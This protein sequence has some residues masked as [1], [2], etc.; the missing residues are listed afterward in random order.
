MQRAH[1]ACRALAAGAVL[2]TAAALLPACDDDPPPAPKPRI[3]AIP[4]RSGSATSRPATTRSTTSAKPLAASSAGATASASSSA[5]PALELRP[6]RKLRDG[7]R[8]EAER[9][10]SKYARLDFSQS[11]VVDLE[12]LGSCSFVTQTTEASTRQ[13]IATGAPTV[14][15]APRASATPSATASGAASATVAAPGDDRAVPSFHLLC[16]GKPAYDFP[17]FGHVD[18]G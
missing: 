3:D 6:A 11:F 16:K 14:D 2:T 13:R 17:G 1:R 9:G 12:G 7:E 5:P 15:A 8:A 18:A 4:A 10:F